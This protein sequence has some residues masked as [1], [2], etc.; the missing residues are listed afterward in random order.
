LVIN[1]PPLLDPVL[2]ERISYLRPA[3]TVWPVDVMT[4]LSSRDPLTAIDAA[5]PASALPPADPAAAEAI[6][7]HSIGRWYLDRG[8]AQAAL[9]AFKRAESATSSPEAQQWLRFREAKALAQLDQTGPAT[10]IL[11]GLLTNQQ[12]SVRRPASA[13]LGSIYLHRGQSRKAV[14]L[15]KRAVEEDEGFEWLERS[16]AEADLGLAYLTVGDAAAGLDRLHRAQSRFE[17][18]NDQEQ[19]AIALENEMKFHEHAGK[20][21]DATA[22]RNRLRQIEKVW[23]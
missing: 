17:H 19:L 23:R 14:G 2:W 22:V 12:S 1:E 18:D 8:H 3:D 9:M 21:G 15:L 16:E 4:L 7:W 11:V 10:A 13:L 20:R 6:V 5:N